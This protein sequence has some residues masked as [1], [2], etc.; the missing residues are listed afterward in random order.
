MEIPSA[1][2]AMDIMV[3]VDIAGVDIANSP[4]M[5]SVRKNQSFFGD[6]GGSKQQLPDFLYDRLKM[7]R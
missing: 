4:S 2:N 5:L 6:A 7:A 3:G 1:S